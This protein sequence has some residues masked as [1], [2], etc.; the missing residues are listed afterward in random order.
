MGPGWGRLRTGQR[1]RCPQR[2]TDPFTLALAITAMFFPSRSALESCVSSPR[3]VSIPSERELASRGGL[4]WR[5][6]NGV[7]KQLFPP[8]VEQTMAFRRSRS[9]GVGVVREGTTTRTYAERDQ[10]SNES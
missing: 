9:G 3:R 2:R 1:S 4:E 7:D 10:E 8:P 6:N 5:A